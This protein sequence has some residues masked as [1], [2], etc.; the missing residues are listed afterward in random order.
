MQHDPSLKPIVDP[1]VPLTQY[2]W[3]FRYPGDP[4]PPTAGEAD[5]ALA[6]VRKA[7]HALLS[8]LPEEI[9]C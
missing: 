9:R 2:A 3:E 8:R 4:E 1:L 6:L 7:L 5:E